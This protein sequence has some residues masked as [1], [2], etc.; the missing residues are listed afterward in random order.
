MLV[1]CGL[2]R[3]AVLWFAVNA[4]FEAVLL[5]NNRYGT[6]LPSD[7]GSEPDLLHL[8]SRIGLAIAVLSSMI[9]LDR[10]RAATLAALR[11]MNADL[12]EAGRAAHAAA[13]AKSRFLATMSHEIRTPLN[14]VMGAAELLKNTPLDGRQVHYLQT[15][16]NSGSNLLELIGN[17]LDFSKLEAGKFVLEHAVFDPRDVVEDVLEALAPHAH[18]KGLL[19]AGHVGRDVPAALG[20]DA[21]RVRQILANLGANAVKFTAAGEVEIRVTRLDDAAPGRSRIRFAVRDTGIGLDVAESAR[22]FQAFTQADGSTTRIYGGT[23][24][25]LAISNELAR[26]MGGELAV[27]SAPGAGAVFHCVLEFTLEGHRAMQ[28]DLG[29]RVILVEP[30]A[31]ARAALVETLYAVGVP[32]TAIDSLASLAP[33]SVGPDTLLVLGPRAVTARGHPA[34]LPAGRRGRLLLIAPYVSTLVAQGPEAPVLYEPIR[35]A[36]LRTSLQQLL[37]AP[38][39]PAPSARVAAAASAP[40]RV[41]LI[42]DNPVNR[43]LATA[44]L[45]QSGCEVDTAEHGGIGVTKWEQGDYDLVLMDCQMPVLDGL[46]ATRRIRAAETAAGRSRVRIVALTANAFAD[47]R[48][49]CLD[50]GMDDFLAKPFTLAQLREVVAGSATVAA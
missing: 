26:L 8:T 46:E 36:V 21:A 4:V 12:T 19:L 25:G 49:R 48:E 23:G 33:E 16:C 14:G 34:A 44:M 40:R 2:H 24:L 18:E 30:A 3:S 9:L 50:A 43:E 6:P 1:N 20:G 28:P 11:R 41:L 39:V 31:T 27:D 45:E 10:A 32:V 35:R 15:L 47:D 7:L 29:A 42:E 37:T 22:L 38:S 17:V 13:E 5:L